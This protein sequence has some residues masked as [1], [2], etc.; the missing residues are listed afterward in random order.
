VALSGAQVQKLA[1]FCL[2]T[3]DA[4]SLAGF[5]ENA[6]GFQRL[7]FEHRSGPVF[8]RLMAVR[9]GAASIILGL[10]R[11]RIELVQLDQPGAPY[12]PGASPRD[13]LF[14]HF[15]IVASDIDE[16]WRR[17]EATPGWS[18]ISI[19][20]PQRLPANSGGV[21]AFKFRDPEGHPLELLSFPTGG[22]PERWRGRGSG[23]L[24]IDHSAICVAYEKLG[25]LPAARTLNS[26][27]EQARLDG[28]V[29]PEVEVISLA[30]PTATPHVE[31]LHY[32]SPA[33]G[34][35]PRTRSH[36]IA[37]TRLLFETAD[38]TGQGAAPQIVDPDGHRLLIVGASSVTGEIARGE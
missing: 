27:P 15:A 6:F 34:V 2:I 35:R 14:Q 23:C 36:D 20:G 1:K 5:Y 18:A 25:L 3:A 10:G 26:G 11:E 38:P 33:R 13:L 28:L 17:L 9:G 21:S 16:A 8:E 30:P 32:T 22:A 29:D 37:A 4:E 19:G 31:L 7:A 24:G 12:P